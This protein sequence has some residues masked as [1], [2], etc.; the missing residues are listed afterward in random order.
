MALDTLKEHIDKLHGLAS[1]LIE[2]ETITREEFVA[3][4]NHP[5]SELLPSQA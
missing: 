5:A 1:L 2:K 4:M 3:F